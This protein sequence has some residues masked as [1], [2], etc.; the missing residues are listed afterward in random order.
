[1]LKEQVINPFFIGKYI[2]DHYFCDR[3]KDTQALVKHIINGRNIALIS[4]RRLGKSGLIH[5]TFNRPEI[6]DSYITIYVDIY[7]TQNLAE[8]AKALSEAIIRTIKIEKG[9]PEK[10][11]AFMKSLKL[12]FKIDSIS[13]EPAIDI[14]VGDIEFPEKTVRELFEYL[15]T[16][17]RPCV[18]A[19]D[20]FQQI[21]EYPEKGIEAYIRTIVQ[22]CPHT[23]FIFCGS[24]RHIMTDM[25]FSPS[26][27]FF[28]SVIS[29]SLH[30]IP[31]DV[32]IDFAGRL[33]AERGK[34]LDKFA[35]EVVYKK[36]DGC[37]WYIQMMMNEMFALTEKG[38]V[39]TTEYI[40]FAWDNII[41]SQED[42]YQSI[43]YHLA[44]KQK[45]ILYAIAKDGKAA[46]ITSSDFIKRHRLVSA[47]SVQAAMKPLLKHDIVTCEEGTFRI[48][49]YFFAAYLAGKYS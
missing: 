4:P 31:M 26:K 23:S 42:R 10:F 46:N 20:E 41:M 40:D 29:Q 34:F 12:G 44:P 32:Y 30:P 22:G 1:M 6:K 43:L 2:G 37:T 36:F 25:F 7:S 21:R 35:A 49:D 18:L 14:C 27:P 33:F 45:Q 11:L 24:K 17:P 16:L 47:S 15:E 38:S 48:Y 13:G 3:E 19:I 39:C 28:Q 8:F 9:W 5:H